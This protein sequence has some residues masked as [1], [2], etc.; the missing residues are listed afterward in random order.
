MK[1]SRKTKT[2]LL[3]EYKKSF[4]YSIYPRH[5]KMRVGGKRVKALSIDA[6]CDWAEQA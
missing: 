4:I 1:N 6:L 3:V 5:L 2:N